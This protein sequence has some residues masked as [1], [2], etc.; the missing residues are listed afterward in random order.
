MASFSVLRFFLAGIFLMLPL[1]GSAQQTDPTSLHAS[2]AQS[3]TKKDTDAIYAITKRFFETYQK[4]DAAHLFGLWDSTCKEFPAF[5]ARMNALFS[6]ERYQ[7]EITYCQTQLLTD[8]SDATAHV[9]VA[10]T[11][12]AAPMTFAEPPLPGITK[13]LGVDIDPEDRSLI[14]RPVPQP[15]LPDGTRQMLLLREL[16]LTKTDHWQITHY[17]SAAHSFSQLLVAP[18]TAAAAEKAMRDMLPDLKT[19]PEICA[20]LRRDLLAIAEN[21]NTRADLLPAQEAT[22]NRAWRKQALRIL[23]GAGLLAA[24]TNDQTGIFWNHLAAGRAYLAL[25]Q[26]AAAEQ[27]LSQAVVTDHN[28]FVSQAIHSWQRHYWAFYYLILAQLA[29]NKQQ[30]ALRTIHEIMPVVEKAQD[31]GWIGVF[32]ALRGQTLARTLPAAALSSLQRCIRFKMDANIIKEAT[33]MNVLLA[34]AYAATDHYREAGKRYKEAQDDYKAWHDDTT[35]ANCQIGLGLAL[36]AQNSDDLAVLKVQEA[37]QRYRVAHYQPGIAAAQLVLV[38]IYNH[39][40]ASSHNR[41][42]H[43]YREEAQKSGT[44]A[45]NLFRKISDTEGILFTVI[46]L[47]NAGA[48][49]SQQDWKMVDWAL[50]QK[51]LPSA[52]QAF[53]SASR[54]ANSALVMTPPVQPTP[55]WIAACQKMQA[56]AEKRGHIGWI[57]AARLNLATMLLAA[58]RLPEAQMWAEK[59][60]QSARISGSLELQWR[61]S[62]TL[63]EIALALHH[64][65]QALEAFRIAIFG[66]EQMRDLVAGTEENQQRYFADKSDLYRRLALLY[67]AR[68]AAHKRLSDATAALLFSEGVKGRTIVDSIAQGRKPLSASLDGTERDQYNHLLQSI[69]TTPPGQP[70]VNSDVVTRWRDK[71]LELALFYEPLTHTRAVQKLIS[72][73]QALSLLSE[74]NMALLEYCVTEKQTLLFLLTKHSHRAS[75]QVDIQIFSIPISRLNLETRSRKFLNH[76][77]NPDAYSVF[78]RDAQQFYHLLVPDKAVQLLKDKKTVIIVPDGTL[79]NVPFHALVTS[80]HRDSLIKYWIEDCA[81][82]YVYS[83]TWLW[84]ER[85]KHR[86]QPSVPLD[87]LVIGNVTPRGSTQHSP[88]NSVTSR[89]QRILGAKIVSGASPEA[90]PRVAA[91]LKPCYPPHRSL[92]KQGHEA[93]LNNFKELA[94]KA[95]VLHFPTHGILDDQEPMNSSLLLYPEKGQKRLNAW[96]IA[97]MQLN[98]EVAVL[99]GC[100][101]SKGA[102]VNGEGLIGLTWAFSLAGCACTIGSQWEVDQGRTDALMLRFHHLLGEQ[103]KHPFSRL[104]KAQLWQCAVRSII[105]DPESTDWQSPA[106]WAGF[107]VVGDAGVLRTISGIATRPKLAIKSSVRKIEDHNAPDCRLEVMLTRSQQ[108]FGPEVSVYPGNVISFCVWLGNKGTAVGRK[109]RIRFQLPPEFEYCPGSSHSLTKRNNQNVDT[110]ISERRV[111]QK[112]NRIEWQFAD[113]DANPS[114]GLFLMF[115]A[116]VRRHGTT[117]HKKQVLRN[118]GDITA[119]ATCAFG[120]KENSVESGTRTDKEQYQER[121]KLLCIAGTCEPQPT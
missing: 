65:S 37:L 107:R 29:E 67:A 6:R 3:S 14:P 17:G 95:R 50:S 48:P 113:M 21:I 38:T 80:S 18:P 118:G 44:E 79:W 103:L 54:L 71:R 42:A 73:P 94:W 30:Q 75:D 112:G 36:S 119:I 74:P 111:L 58:K 106:Y 81:I 88:Q 121:T 77:I 52:I 98:A 99:A 4:Q 82:S 97:E 61:T 60:N 90:F 24:A 10:F 96:D 114:A 115:Q 20:L 12:T 28:L 23:I 26:Y 35:L 49:L 69:N 39:L 5:K 66:I 56:L 19:S 76:A 100:D 116:Q 78:L 31:K 11:L 2:P 102:A 93:T 89:Q 101:T 53:G 46:A 62:R 51:T 87:L 83:L 41:I 117:V 33:W 63:G 70:G 7:I 92:V 27:E 85:Q 68:Y 59:A 120:T 15:P 9:Y 86:E 25:I 1:V 16:N 13:E 34:D 57:A 84:Q 105:S 109:P 91:E 104:T 72:A 8:G 40:A 110:D 108:V 45:L 64:E 22:A 43:R 32:E 55:R 47:Q